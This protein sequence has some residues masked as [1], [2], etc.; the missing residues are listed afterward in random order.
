M[1]EN[2]DPFSIVVRGLALI[3]VAL[4]GVLEAYSAQPIKDL[5]RLSVSRKMNLAC[6][7]GAI[8]E[9]EREALLAAN[10]IRNDAAHR[11]DF[12]VTQADEQ[13]L[14]ELFKA[15][16]RMFQGLAYDPQRFPRGL[17]FVL[18]TMFWAIHIRCQRKD[19]KLKFNDDPSNLE[20]MLAVVIVRTAD[21]ARRLR[22]EDDDAAVQKIAQR[23][24][25]EAKALQDKNA[26]GESNV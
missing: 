8:S 23:F 3:D 12:V 1:V 22:V 20:A 9:G 17:V 21:E 2:M 7:L 16:V 26:D 4:K 13:R 14:V 5:G 18:F 24:S 19:V 10:K 15:K 25:E 11:L 6:T